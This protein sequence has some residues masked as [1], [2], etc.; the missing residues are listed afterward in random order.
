MA[1]FFPETLVCLAAATTAAVRTPPVSG[2]APD[3][4]TNIQLDNDNKTTI[5]GGWQKLPPDAS[6]R[7]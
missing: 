7:C 5:R 2:I 3:N 6:F 1:F 4:T